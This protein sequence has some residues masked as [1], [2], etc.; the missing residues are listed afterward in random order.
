[1]GLLLSHAICQIL[2][3]IVACTA[4]LRSIRQDDRLQYPWLIYSAKLMPI[5]LTCRVGC[6]LRVAYLCL[7]PDEYFQ[8]YV[9]LA[10]LIL[11]R[12]AVSKRKSVPFCGIC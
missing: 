2:E 1:M 12:S 11:S 7:S 3:K 6:A 10:N 4:L 9:R 8:L 5:L